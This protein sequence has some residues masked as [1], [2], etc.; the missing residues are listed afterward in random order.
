VI[1]HEIKNKTC[2]ELGG[3]AGQAGIYPA[4]ERVKIVRSPSP[5]WPKPLGLYSDEV[6]SRPFEDVLFVSFGSNPE[7]RFARARLLRSL[8]K[9]FKYSSQYI[10]NQDWLIQTTM[11]QQNRNFFEENRRGY[12][13]WAW[14]P[15]LILDAILRFPKAKYIIYLDMGCDLNINKNSIRRLEDYLRLA[16]TYEGFAFELNLKE[17]EWTSKH[18]LEYFSASHSQQNQVSASVIIFKNTKKVELFLDRW[19]ALMKNNNFYLTK[20]VRNPGAH[21]I[22]R[23]RHD[24]SILSLI[25]HQSTMFAI[26]DETYLKSDQKF[27]STKP[28][29]VSRNREIFRIDSPVIFRQASRIARR[30]S[31]LIY[32]FVQ[33]ISPRVA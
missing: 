15:L 4:S 32:G 7:W 14:K 5:S 31:L 19:M 20:N 10:V 3:S 12:G 27:D 30:I 1:I 11:Y 8:R 6:S 24:Q 28:F 25:W 13:L 26:P 21:E 23:H 17:V 18:V 29:W 2:F 16:N 33:E 9:Y 22:D